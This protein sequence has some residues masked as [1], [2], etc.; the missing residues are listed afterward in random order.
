MTSVTVQLSEKEIQAIKARTGKR[1]AAA[2]LKAWA[3][4][5]NPKRSA[6]QLRTA[7]RQSLKE[8]AAGRGRRFH[9]GREAIRWLES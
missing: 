2:A 5:A 8:E 3:A 6:S 9:T 4:R 7:L 1:S